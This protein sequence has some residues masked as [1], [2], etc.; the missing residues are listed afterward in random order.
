MPTRS[1]AALLAALALA[2]APGLARAHANLERKEANPDSAY[3]GVVQIMHGC[4]GTPTTR[5]TVTIPEGVVGAKP[6]PKPGWQVAVTRGA[7]AR[8]YQSF[9]GTV[10]EGVK[11]II[12][13]GGSLPDDQIDE[14]TFFARVSDAFAPGATIHFPIEQDCEKGSYRWTE[15]PAAGQDPRELKSPAPAVRVVAAEGKTAQA[16]AKAGTVTVTAP[17]IRATP[18]GAKVAG[19]YFT[20]S[21][22][23]REPDKLLSATAEIAG[24][25]SIHS[26]SIENGVMRMAPVENGLAIKSGE[27]AE[28]KPGGYHLMLEDL[29]R[30]PKAGESVKGSVTFERAGTVPVV[31]EVR[32][33]APAAASGGHQH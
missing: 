19:G 26:M 18:A 8:P 32:G 33:T 14:F 13:S 3:R 23:G 6:M 12:W 10:S 30:P 28:L 22:S 29:K 9:H 1:P 5:V 17:W 7:Y 27:A 20:A 31:F 16:P 24:R 11:T 2:A 4:E 15:V 21:N 25:V